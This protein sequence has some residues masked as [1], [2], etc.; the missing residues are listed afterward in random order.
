MIEVKRRGKDYALAEKYIS[1]KISDQSYPDTTIFY[2]NTKLKNIDYSFSKDLEKARK[3]KLFKVRL[4][5]TSQYYKGYSIKV[6][7]R[8][9]MFHLKEESVADPEIPI[10]FFTRFEK[11]RAARK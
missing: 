8:E 1:K 11:D 4:I 3:L 2:Y 10:S 6:P 7:R 9:F 5:Y